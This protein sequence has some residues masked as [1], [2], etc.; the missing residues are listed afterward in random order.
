MGHQVFVESDQ[1]S[2]DSNVDDAHAQLANYAYNIVVAATNPPDIPV[3][4]Q[5]HFFAEILVPCG[6]AKEAC[7]RSAVEAGTCKY[8]TGSLGTV[9]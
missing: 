8:T 7:Y 5:L 3:L 2:A 4:P 6:Q 9:K 1:G